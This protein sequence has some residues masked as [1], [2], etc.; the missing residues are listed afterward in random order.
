MKVSNV[1]DMFMDSAHRAVS[2]LHEDPENSKEAIRACKTGFV[3][4]YNILQVCKCVFCLALCWIIEKLRK[5]LIQIT[6]EMIQIF[7]LV[8]VIIL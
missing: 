5:S 2:L 8:R 1:V 7:A 3:L 6:P 4:M